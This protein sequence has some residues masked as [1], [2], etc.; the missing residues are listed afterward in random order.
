M[1]NV[2]DLKA[3]EAT[4][5]LESFRTLIELC[6]TQIAY[7]IAGASLAVQEGQ[8]GT[9]AQATVHENLFEA[10]AKGVARD[11][12]PV[13]QEL[14]DWMVE[15]NFGQGTPAPRI[16]FD[17]EDYATFSDVTE[18][19]DRGVP[20]SREALYSRYG[21]PRPS[22]AEDSFEKPAAPAPGLAFADEGK[23]KAQALRPRPRQGIVLIP[24][25]RP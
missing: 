14:L 24:R 4:G 25:R 16:E 1:A 10:Q 21:L 8:N 5:S 17:L 23:K 2:K 13:L 22:D 11:L 12:Q 20:V 9:R 15:L 19:I 3:L 7:A 18:A 6:D